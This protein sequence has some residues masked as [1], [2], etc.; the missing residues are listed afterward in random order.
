[1]QIVDEGMKTFGN[2]LDVSDTS[3]SNT[4]LP[5][6]K[7]HFIQCARKRKNKSRQQTNNDNKHNNENSNSNNNSSVKRKG[8]PRKT[9]QSKNVPTFKLVNATCYQKNAIVCYLFLQSIVT[10]TCSSN[11]Y[12][13]TKYQVYFLWFFVA[14]VSFNIALLSEIWVSSKLSCHVM[15]ISSIQMGIY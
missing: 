9:K 10:M 4:E 7:E 6:Q 14:F 2:D 15:H 1:M 12:A 3:S 11:P 5:I 13:R 8:S